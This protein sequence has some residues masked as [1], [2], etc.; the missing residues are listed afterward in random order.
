MS[1]EFPYFVKNPLLFW[2]LKVCDALIYKKPKRGS[3]TGAKNLLIGNIAHLGDVALTLECI[4][5][6]QSAYPQSKLYF[7]SSSVGGTLLN[8]FQDLN[9]IIVFDHFKHQRNRSFWKKGFYHI[10]SFI[11]AIS[12]IKDYAID[13]YI[14]T[15]PFYPNGLFLS[16]CANIPFRMGYG[17]GGCISLLTKKLHIQSDIP[18]KLQNQAHLKKFGIPLKKQDYANKKWLELPE[19]FVLVHLEASSKKKSCCYQEIKPLL[20]A[21][22]GPSVFT[23]TSASLKEEIDKYGVQERVINLVGKCQLDELVEVL[24]RAAKV[25]CV[26]TVVLHLAEYFSIP[27][28]LLKKER[29]EQNLFDPSCPS[30]QVVIIEEGAIK[31][32]AIQT[33]SQVF[34]K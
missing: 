28:L 31:D 27:T 7:L 14:E 24:R 8:V 33:A 12:L 17:T 29:I 16:A 25:V 19:N 26:D 3:L 22:L 15:Y 21:Y 10:T 34:F 20:S 5:S 18:L 1:C 30:T 11:K 2:Y 6:I 32:A 4:A 23:G 9:R 13:L